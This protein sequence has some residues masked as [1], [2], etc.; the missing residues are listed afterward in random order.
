MSPSFKPLGSHST[1]YTACL[2]CFLSGPRRDPSLIKLAI[3][4]HQ[5][6]SLF[7]LCLW[8]LTH[9]LLCLEYFLSFTL[10]KPWRPSEMSTSGNLFPPLLDGLYLFWTSLRGGILPMS[11]VWKDCTTVIFIRFC[12]SSLLSFLSSRSAE[13][14]AVLSKYLLSG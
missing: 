4:T 7:F 12:P 2:A 11:L 1:K 5:Y 14:V 10:I 6:V 9:W 3:V 8:H 13:H